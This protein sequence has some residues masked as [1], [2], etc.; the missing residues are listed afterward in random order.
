[1]V[2]R[3]LKERL[4]AATE[5]IDDADRKLAAHH[6]RVRKIVKTFLTDLRSVYAPGANKERNWQTPTRK[7]ANREK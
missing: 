7:V 3:P 4:D 5:V 1:M 6:L 2:E